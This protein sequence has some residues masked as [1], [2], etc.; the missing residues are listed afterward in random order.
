MNYFINF[1]NYGNPN[2]EN[3]AAEDEFWPRYNGLT[4]VSISLN[5]TDRVIYNTPDSWIGPAYELSWNSTDENPEPTT[6]T[7]V[8][9]NSEPPTTTTTG[10]TDP[11]NSESPTTTTTTEKPGGNTGA[12]IN[13]VYSPSILLFLSLITCLNFRRH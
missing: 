4:H 2:G 6:A 1:V 8:P 11:N 7:T 12:G 9:N 3:V 10:T 13:L 5:R